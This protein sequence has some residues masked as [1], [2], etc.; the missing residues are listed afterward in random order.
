MTMHPPHQLDAARIDPDRITID[1]GYRTEVARVLLERSGDSADHVELRRLARQVFPDLARADHATHLARLVG[2][3]ATL[4]ASTRDLRLDDV[5]PAA[6]RRPTHP[7]AYPASYADIDASTRALLI[8][9]CQAELEAGRDGRD[10]LD[11]LDRL[12]G[13]PYS[14]RTFFVG[15]WKAARIRSRP[16]DD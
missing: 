15:P 7:L 11:S 12:H 14:D 6:L 3:A 8:R 16:R 1:P 13:W 9:H 4:R 5:E 2:S 10:A